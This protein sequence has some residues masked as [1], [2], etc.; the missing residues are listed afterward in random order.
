MSPK[1]QILEEAIKISCYNGHSIQYVSWP[2]VSGLTQHAITQ[3]WQTLLPHYAGMYRLT[4]NNAETYWIV[5]RSVFS[6]WLRMDLKFDL[7]VSIR[8]SLSQ[9][10]RKAVF[11]TADSDTQSHVYTHYCN[12]LR[13]CKLRCVF[14][15][16]QAM[17]D[18]T[19]KRATTSCK[20]TEWCPSVKKL[21]LTL[22]QS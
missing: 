13:V 16:I 5:M 18:P 20:W 15:H 19:F 11:T 21:K 4:V 12:K 6:C 7:K 14:D 17:G 3:E 10:Q 1:C 8:G 2:H 22:C 9:W